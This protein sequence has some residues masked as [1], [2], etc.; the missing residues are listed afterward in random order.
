[1]KGF[2]GVYWRTGI[3]IQSHQETLEPSEIS[4]KD[5]ELSYA[6]GKEVRR[7]ILLKISLGETTHGRILELS[8]YL[9]LWHWL[10]RLNGILLWCDRFAVLL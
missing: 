9:C 5:D 8:T 4:D 7:A 1:M 2:L 6:L 10:R 3:L